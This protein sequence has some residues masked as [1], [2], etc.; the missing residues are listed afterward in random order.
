M[1]STLSYL[2]EDVRLARCGAVWPWVLCQLAQVKDGSGSVE[3]ERLSPRLAAQD[4]NIPLA[5]AKR[6]IASAI[7]YG[8][9]SEEDGELTTDWEYEG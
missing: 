7:E 8:L 5:L 1:L 9:L 4:L 3:K 6:Q 2:D